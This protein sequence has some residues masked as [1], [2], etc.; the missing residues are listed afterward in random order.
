M[1]RGGAVGKTEIRPLGADS[2]A[3]S[4]AFWVVA[5]LAG[6]LIVLY[7]FAPTYYLRHWFRTTPLPGLLQLHGALMTSWFVL[8]FVQVSLIA[9]HRR[10][11]SEKLQTE[12]LIRLGD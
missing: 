6:F 5:G 3:P 2:R 7:G 12:A 8:F 1:L 9:R 11:L 4:H 10:N